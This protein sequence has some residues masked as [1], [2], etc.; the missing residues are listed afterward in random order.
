MKRTAEGILV[1]VGVIINLIL[2]AGGALISVVSKDESIRTELEKE[3]ANDPNLAS[4]G[5]DPTAAMNMIES[6]GWGFV[7]I[8]AIST[9][10]S[11]IALFSMRRNKKPKLAGGLLIISALIVGLATLFIGWLPAL[12]FLIAGIMCFA[13]KE[14]NP[15]YGEKHPADSV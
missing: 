8:V 9:I 14:K 10:L 6:V 4:A 13:R 12:L 15:M 1:I 11:V 7:A 5:L 2:I 3:L